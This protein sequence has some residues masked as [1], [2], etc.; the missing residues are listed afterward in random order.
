MKIENATDAN[1]IISTAI[2][3]HD[4]LWKAIQNSEDY[5]MNYKAPFDEEK[6]KEQKI[7]WSNNWNYGKGKMLVEQGV[8]SNVTEMFKT[9]SMIEILFNRRGKSKNPVF[10]FLDNNFLRYV[11]G[12]RIA[13]VFADVLEND[14]R[15][16]TFITQIE[17]SSYM[18]GYSPIIR[19]KFTY[20]GKPISRKSIA[21]E[22]N[23]DFSDIRNF[24]VFDTMKA[25]VL[26][27]KLEECLK[28]EKEKIEA[29]EQEFHRYENGW[30]K[31]GMEDIFY[32]ILSE[33]SEIHDDVKSGTLE[34]EAKIKDG[35]LKIT[36]WEDVEKISAKKKLVFYCISL[37]IVD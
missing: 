34:L 12:N 24:V 15:F 36:S 2:E 29:R 1:L 9:L 28:L 18:F 37:E 33:C 17:Y 35:K 16:Q 32:N 22:D 23:T 6:R 31:E 3:S 21:F 10:E 4:S 14:P 25:E 19:D 30:I 5:I 8:V 11:I 26:L 13:E 20:L 27:Q 7:S